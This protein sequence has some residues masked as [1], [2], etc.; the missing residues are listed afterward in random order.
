MHRPEQSYDK[1]H[2]S[3]IDLRSGSQTEPLVASQDFHGTA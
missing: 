2:V 3:T 1:V